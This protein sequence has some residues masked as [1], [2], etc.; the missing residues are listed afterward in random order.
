MLFCEC[1]WRSVPTGLRQLE[2]LRN[3]AELLHPEHGHYMLFS[4]NGFDEHV[5]SRAAQA[6]DVTLVDFGS[7]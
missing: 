4:K 7:M 5:T 3:R 6:D 1:K 2:T